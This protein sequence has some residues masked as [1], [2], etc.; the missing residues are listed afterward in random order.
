M[1]ILIDTKIEKELDLPRVFNFSGGKTSAYM[2][3]KYYQK[4]DL[5]IFCD[6]GRE[7][8][9]TYKF[10]ND[11]EA[12]ENIPVI[13]LFYEGGFEA[14]LN[15]RKGVPNQFR[16]YCTIELKIKTCRRY[17]VSKGIK[18]YVNIIGFRNDEQ[19]RIKT[20]KQMWKKVYDWFPLNEDNTNKAIVNEYWKSKKYNLEI[21]S[22]LGNCDLC[23]VYKGKNAVINILSVYPELGDKWIADEERS[24]ERMDGKKKK[25]HTYFDG[26]TI[27]QLRDI[28]QNNLFKGKINLEELIPAFNCACTT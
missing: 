7:H 9:K 16:R 21:P 12:F 24:K 11:F 28:A 1:N 6:T 14:L 10:I 18:S 26:I 4:G 2:T 27:S 5:V 25:G 19:R 8:P 3:I 20:R 23:P 17:L 15:K 13:R 22:I